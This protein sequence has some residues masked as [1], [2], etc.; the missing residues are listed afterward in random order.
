MKI[1]LNLIKKIL[2]IK[3]IIISLLIIILVGQFFFNTT[4]SNDKEIIKIEGKK[5]SIEKTT[6]DTVYVPIETIKYIKGKDIYHEKIVEKTVFKTPDIDSMMIVADYFNK[7]L[8]QD[9]LILNDNL[10]LI[11]VND[12]IY[13]NKV[14][15]RRYISVIDIP[16][17]KT[18]TY[19]SPLPRYQLY[20]G[21][22]MSINKQVLFSSVGIGLQ[23]K[24]KQ[25]HMLG[26]SV[27]FMN[28]GS[29]M[30]VPYIGGSYYR[31]LQFKN[32]SKS[33]LMTRKLL[34]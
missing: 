6:T 24:N 18:N 14:L 32:V 21:L 13:Q 29:N 16:E 30:V 23:L 9:T 33:S 11:I 27:G 8:Y 25:D 19:I 1:D 17:T 3:T 22:E 10:G 20:Y 28:T 4:P 2:D 31:K 34:K 26:I 12:T 5:Y 15:S 7:Y